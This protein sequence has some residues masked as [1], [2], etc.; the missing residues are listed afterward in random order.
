MS[1]DQGHRHV[2]P[3][4]P[5]SALFPGCGPDTVP[6]A[7]FDA[8][9]FP[10]T[11][12]GAFPDAPADAFPAPSPDPFLTTGND[13]F[14]ALASAPFPA[15]DNAL[16]PTPTPDPFPATAAD[17]FPAAAAPAEACAAAPSHSPAPA[18]ATAGLFPSEGP[19]ALAPADPFPTSPDA[20]GG[21]DHK[22]MAPYAAKGM[23]TVCVPVYPQGVAQQQDQPFFFGPFL[24]QKVLLNRHQLLIPKVSS[25][26]LC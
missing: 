10:A 13:P 17:P 2:A 11:V 21:A 23:S 24:E 22:A 20:F 1:Q 26:N 8:D 4:P 25:A 14:P 19:A 15:T 9:P 7:P 16:L 3:P 6:A 18:P 5:S 12:S